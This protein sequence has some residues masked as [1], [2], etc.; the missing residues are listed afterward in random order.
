VE[1]IYRVYSALQFDTPVRRALNTSLEHYAMA[2]A[3]KTVLDKFPGELELARY[4]LLTFLLKLRKWTPRL[5]L[6]AAF[7]NT[8]PC[9]ST[10][11]SRLCRLSFSTR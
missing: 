5:E 2:G 10:G 11:R 7:D 9:V 6:K 3:L 1:T 8:S 4:Q